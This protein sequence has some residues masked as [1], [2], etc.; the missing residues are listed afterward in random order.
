MP[1]RAVSD[2]CSSCKA[3]V[4]NTRGLGDHAP[5]R[6]WFSTGRIGTTNQDQLNGRHRVTHITP[7]GLAL[8]GH[9][10]FGQF[11]AGRA[12][13]FLL[14][15]RPHRASLVERTVHALRPEVAAGWPLRKVSSNA[16]AHS[17]RR[18]PTMAAGS[19][20]PQGHSMTLLLA[21]G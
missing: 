11:H 1:L 15:Q 2:R 20:T 5:G 8:C 21:N 17:A 19:A 3:G 14:L 4:R 16:L 18:P 13:A 12:A 6:R 9:G 10:L 7:N